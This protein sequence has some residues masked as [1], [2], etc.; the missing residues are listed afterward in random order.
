MVVSSW[1]YVRQIGGGDGDEQSNPGLRTIVNKS[2]IISNEFRVFPMEVIAGDTDLMVTVFENNCTF[3][4][5]YENVYWNSRLSTE[6]GR[7]VDMMK[8]GQIIGM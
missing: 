5:D 1:M 7:V 2:D 3:S 6:H 4:F 8:Q